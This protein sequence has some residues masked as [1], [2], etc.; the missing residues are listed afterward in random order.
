MFVHHKG[1]SFINLG[2]KTIA[3]AKEKL[4]PKVFEKI[5]EKL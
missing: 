4:F 5:I 2:P 3:I 1:I